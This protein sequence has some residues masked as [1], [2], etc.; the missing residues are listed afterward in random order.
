MTTIAIIGAGAVGSAVGGNWAAKGHT[1]IYGVRD[2]QGDKVRAVVA[3]SG[4]NASAA[5]P[6]EAAAR[7]D[8]VV[9]ATPWGAAEDAVGS[10]GDLGGK[11]LMDATN[12]LTMGPEGFSLEIG[13]TVSGG[14][15]VAEWA[16]TA[17]VVKTLN[18]VGA[19]AMKDPSAFTAKPVMLVAGDDPA[20]RALAIALVGDLGFDARDAGP[21]RVARLIEPFAMTWIHMA[22]VAGAGR[23]WAFAMVPRA[24]A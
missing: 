9:L 13:H 24:G 20:A 10:L 2:P 4:P 14:E 18:Q 12:P 7:A 15:R 6:A 16:P 19:E 23:D 5:T 3:V 17:R 22:L 8:A 11:L 21:L 1:V